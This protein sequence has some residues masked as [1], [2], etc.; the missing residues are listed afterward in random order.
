[1]QSTWLALPAIHAAGTIKAPAT[2]TDRGGQFELW[3]Q[4]SSRRLRVVHPSGPDSVTV[5]TDRKAWRRTGPL[6]NVL[7]PDRV[8][9]FPV[10]DPAAP[11]TTFYRSARRWSD[12]GLSTVNGVRCEKVTGSSPGAEFTF[13]LNPSTHLPVA[14]DLNIR[15]GAERG[16]WRV[17]YQ[18]I[19]TPG[20]LPPALFQRP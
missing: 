11:D 8:D 16:L 1:M 20:H 10:P 12:G 17:E 4:G 5:V 18:K 14:V 2:A 19:D 7:D 13:Y 15:N 6:L 9:L 3:E